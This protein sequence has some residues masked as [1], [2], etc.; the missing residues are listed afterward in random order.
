MG[1]LDNQEETG[2]QGSSDKLDLIQYEKKLVQKFNDSEILGT[3]YK[4]EEFG[5]TFDK[6][7][8]ESDVYTFED[9]EIITICPEPLAFIKEFDD[10]SDNKQAANELFLE[11]IKGFQQ[12]KLDKK[13]LL[14]A[15][16]NYGDRMWMNKTLNGINLRPG[17]LNDDRENFAPIRMCDDNV[18]G[19][20]VGR[21]GS[22]KSVYINALILSLITEYA[23]WELNLYLADFKKVEL[24]RYMN[25]GDEKNEYTPFTP[26]INACA[27]TSEI[28]YVISLIKYLVDCMN[29]RQEFFARLG[30][31]KIQE[32]RNKYNLVLPRVLLMVD[33]FQ[34]LFTEATNREA[35]EIQTMLNAI[36]KLGRATGFHLIFAS[37]EMS[38]TLSGNTLANFK[39][40]MALPCN[41]QISVDILG[42]GK[43]TNLERGYVLVNTDS[44]DELKNKKYRVPF[45]ETDKK[46]DD[47]N[48][49]KTPFYQYLDEIK[50]A[51]RKFDLEYKTSIQKFY[52][53]EL[54]ESE[55][56]Y[57]KDLDRIKEKKN[58]LVRQN[59]A[60]FDG[61]ILGKSVLYSPLKNDKVSFYIE[62]G[63]NK[64]MMIATPNPDDA[65]R[66]RKLLAENLFRS[67]SETYH[68]GMELNN[69]VLE[70]YR[71]DEAIRNY[72]MHRYFSCEADKALEYFQ[73][74]YLLRQMASKKLD[75]IQHEQE[76]IRALEGK[77]VSLLDD[78]SQV[79]K[80]QTF[81]DAKSKLLSAIENLSD[82]ISRTA[83]L[84]EGKMA[85]PVVRYLEKCSSDVVMIPIDGTKAE[86]Y[87]LPLYEDVMKNY[88]SDLDVTHATKKNIELIDRKIAE[89]AGENTE[90]KFDLPILQNKIFRRA[91]LFYLDKYN[92]REPDHTS[93]S[94]ALEKCYLG[95]RPFI[96]P[97][98]TEC[99][100]RREAIENNQRLTAQRDE[101]QT[102][103]DELMMNPDEISKTDQALK[104]H[105]NTFVKDIFDNV[106]DKLGYR[107]DRPEVPEACYEYC[108][109]EL[110]WTLGGCIVNEAVTSCANDILDRYISVCRGGAYT[111]DSF[112][113]VVFWIN[114]MDEIDRIP[115]WFDDAVRNAINY[116][117][118]VIAIITSELKD[119]LIRKAFD[120]SFVTGNI[121][122]FYSMFD[123]K[124]TKQPLDSIVVNFGIR[125]KGFDIPFKMY[126]SNLGDI[127]APDF[128]DQL[129]NE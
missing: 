120:Y 1:F 46:D 101:L 50:L 99:E 31:T 45:I 37:Q 30:V 121:E 117:I 18:H 9:D 25:D 105:I 76:G 64:G 38:G 93:L 69:L 125:S 48:E 51:G 67:D 34:Q 5:I 16:D 10:V 33:E 81:E 73:M 111:G 42:N 80:H 35:E 39:I 122:K 128:I 4:A 58:Q 65:A 114:G 26:H 74:I 96:N 54:Q 52:R 92:D 59:R 102:Q 83:A 97:Y 57:R 72:P 115:N 66:I 7:K 77:L 118:L 56:D 20:I 19:L 119:P 29:A 70:R 78:A 124:Y 68:L 98:K 110:M 49:E 106:F 103:L 82:E 3:K 32:F 63:R 22:G 21:T 85:N 87:N 61:I 113:K 91:L 36:T 88:A 60:L 11:K 2:S 71:I 123:I 108:N 44:G 55:N 100:S 90:G 13:P 116:N 40:R 112:R 86:F 12:L 53:E 95:V 28:R 75:T 89:L 43:A 109:G 47:D 107:K 129:L 8:R 14:K 23:P 104:Q 41:Q 126:K 17:N 94:D 27:A 79:A 84:S 127:Q 15:G 62:R 6:N 24:S